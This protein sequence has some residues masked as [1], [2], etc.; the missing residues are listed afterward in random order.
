EHAQKKSRG[1][2]QMTC[3]RL[4]NPDCFRIGELANAGSSKLAA[5]TGAL[6][7]AEGQTRI[8]YDHAVDE[9]HSCFQLRSEKLLLFFVVRPRARPQA[10][11]AVVGHP[12]SLAF[13]PR[14]PNRA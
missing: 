14:P 5:E 12:A 2:T 13:L 4:R 9:N 11:N 8:G 6:H 1:A 7:A 10:V 3:A